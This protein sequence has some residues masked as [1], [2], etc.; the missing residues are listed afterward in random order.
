MIWFIDEYL[1]KTLSEMKLCPGV[2]VSL[3]CHYFP[4]KDF[5]LSVFW[6]DP[7]VNLNWYPIVQIDTGHTTVFHCE[8]SEDP[9]H[10]ED[11]LTEA[12]SFLKKWLQK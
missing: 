10:Y 2:D 5:C 8:G 7:S 6:H 1:E 4:E 12:W 11:V 9:E 3:E